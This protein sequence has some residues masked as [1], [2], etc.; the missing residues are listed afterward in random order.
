MGQCY[1]LRFSANDSLA[2]PSQI[3]PVGHVIDRVS[4][5]QL[6]NSF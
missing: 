3:G 6:I 4:K 5:T 1:K 2:L